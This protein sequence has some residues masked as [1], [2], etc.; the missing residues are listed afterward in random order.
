[1]PRAAVEKA[2][3]LSLRKSVKA[4]H[5]FRIPTLWRQNVIFHVNTKGDGRVQS[6]MSTNATATLWVPNELRM[7]DLKKP[8]SE[9]V[10]EVLTAGEVANYLRVSLSTIYRLLKSGDL[11]AFKIGSDWRFNRVHVEEWLKSRTQAA[12][13]DSQDHLITPS[14]DTNSDE[15]RRK[16]N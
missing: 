14:V 16:P 10:N 2:K 13:P 3:A 9:R 11:P 5:L 1:L 12:G 8:N 15:S 6:R 7:K 4:F